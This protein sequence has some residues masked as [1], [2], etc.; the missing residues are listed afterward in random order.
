MG[1]FTGGMYN[2]QSVS[3][4]KSSKSP[5]LQNTATALRDACKLPAPNKMDMYSTSGGKFGRTSRNTGGGV[6]VK[7]SYGAGA[8]PHSPE[9]ANDIFTEQCEDILVR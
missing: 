1:G 2:S 8:T 4:L 9:D 6:L 7:A 5:A 3:K